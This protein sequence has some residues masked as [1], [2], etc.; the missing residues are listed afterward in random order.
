MKKV[1]IIITCL[2]M[3]MLS[4]YSQA[5]VVVNG[6]FEQGPCPNFIG[7][8]P[9]N[10]SNVYFDADLISACDT[11]EQSSYNDV[12]VPC[13]W[14][15]CQYPKDGSN[16]LALCLGSEVPE[17][18]E[19]VRGNLT[20]PLVKDSLYRV[21]FWYTRA[22]R[23]SMGSNNIGAYF[24]HI[25]YQNPYQLDYSVIDYNKLVYE[26][27][28]FC[29]TTNWILFDQIYFAGGGETNIYIGNFF[30]DAKSKIQECY[31]TDLHY[32]YY[33][34][35]DVKIERIL[36]VGLANDNPNKPKIVAIYDVLGTKYDNYINGMNI[37]IYSNGRKQKVFKELR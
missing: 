25:T 23:Y 17:V 9:D 3:L 35:D 33:Y 12:G 34:I 21:T 32:A 18:R 19:W 8:L 4:I 15:G 7:M 28:F 11:S 29:D 6:S 27:S 14:F 20:A 10:W 13:N 24:G 22:D 16:Y 31:P 26:P 2:T 1:K 37:V 36:W 5:Q 30:P